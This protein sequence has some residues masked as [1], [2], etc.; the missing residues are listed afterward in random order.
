MGKTLL[1]GRVARGVSQVALGEIFEILED[2]LCF[3]NCGFGGLLVDLW[4]L[5]W[6][7]FFVSLFR[8][9]LGLNL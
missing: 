3:R 4:R 2:L 5:S 9:P 8:P 6:H 1:D 7:L